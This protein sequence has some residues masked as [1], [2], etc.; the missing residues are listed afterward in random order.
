M[1]EFSGRRGHDFKTVLCDIETGE[2]LEVID[3]HKQKEIIESLCLQALEV[4]EAIEEVSIDMWGGFRKVVQEAFPN[5]VIVYDRFHV[6]RMVNE[7]VKK[8]ARQCGLGKR[9]EQFLLLKNGV[10][11]NA[12][13]KVQLET[14]LQID[15]R[16]RKAYEYKEEFRWIYERSQSVDEGQQKLEDWLL[17]ARKVYG[18]VVQTITEHFEGVCNYFIRRSSSGVMEGINNRIKLIKRQ[19]YGFTNFEN[20][21]LR[22]L[23]GFAKKGCCSP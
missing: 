4:R 3:S 16:L 2:L 22:L 6:M 15:K 20:L 7:E 8:I 21:R 17:K 12:G 23:A 18:K 10:D 11:L 19:G 13:Q 9:K 1:D 5:A 14:Y